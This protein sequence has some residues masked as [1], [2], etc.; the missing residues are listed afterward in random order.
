[1]V[2]IRQAERG[3]RAALEACFSELQAFERTIERNRAEP[4]AVC[5]QYL[6]ELEAECAK[7]KGVFL[8]AESAGNVV[9]FVC[10][11]AKVPSDEVV[12]QEREYA[13]VTDL[14]VLEPFR[15]LGIGSL[16]LAAA[17]AYVAQ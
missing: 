14:V 11:L 13:F 2:T 10:V 8:V 17:E 16:L 1:M 12:E 3:D 9:G 6:D 15:K 7:H 5:A 4:A